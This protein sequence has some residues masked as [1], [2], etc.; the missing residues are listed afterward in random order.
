MADERVEPGVTAVPNLQ[1]HIARYN[2]SLSHCVNKKVLDLAC[3]TG[4]GT[5]LISR[6][7]KS[8]VGVD[9]S[10]EAINCATSN[11]DGDNIFYQRDDFYSVTGK[12]DTVVCF[13]TI[14]HLKDIEKTEKKL[15][16]LLRPGGTL[17]FSVPL[18]E[19]KGFNEHHHHTFNPTQAKNLFLGYKK[20]LEVIQYGIIFM[21]ALESWQQPFSYYVA[22]VKNEK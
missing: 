17:V 9:K 21:E 20:D 16:D 19:K 5:Q 1:K 2:L 18:N 14:E 7:A 13:E 10:M 15:M 11:Y 6:V 8:V 12:Y 4:Y 22:V 3:G